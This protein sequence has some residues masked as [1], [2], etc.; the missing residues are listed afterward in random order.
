[1]TPL[2]ALLISIAVPQGTPPDLILYNAKIVTLNTRREIAE[3]VAILSGKFI[4][5]GKNADVRRL[6]ASSTRQ[7]DLAGRTVIPGLADGH[8]HGIGGGPGVDLSKARS[9]DDLLNAV[10]ERAAKIREGE[11]IVSN[12][13]WHEGQLKE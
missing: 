2:L 4:A 3:A 10:R 12:S 5:I 13:D 1:M 7:I 6:A 11:V 8:Y 9:I